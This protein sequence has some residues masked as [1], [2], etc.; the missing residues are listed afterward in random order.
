MTVNQRVIR[1]S[2][3]GGALLNSLA[4][5]A[6]LFSLNPHQDYI[7]ASPLPLFLWFGNHYLKSK[8]S[9]ET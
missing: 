3:I 8:V 2:R 1:S 6:G 4:I 5:F 9:M 7:P